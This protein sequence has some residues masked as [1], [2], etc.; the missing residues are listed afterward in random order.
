MCKSIKAPT[1][2]VD[3]VTNYSYL[4]YNDFRYLILSG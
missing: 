3:A 2:K 1:G 4:C